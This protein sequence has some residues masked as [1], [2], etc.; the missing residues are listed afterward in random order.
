MRA[1]HET[2]VDLTTVVPY[3]EMLA[4]ELRNSRLPRTTAELS[5][6]SDAL[7]CAALLLR[8]Q[9]AAPEGNTTELLLEAMAVARSTVESTKYAC[10]ARVG[11]RAGVDGARA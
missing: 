5:A 4:S 10:R 7:T 6:A 9:Q 3:L 11:S 1:V 8:T 2:A